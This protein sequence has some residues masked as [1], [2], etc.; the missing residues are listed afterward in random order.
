MVD[1]VESQ[2]IT[3][4][5]MLSAKQDAVQRMM[6][7]MN[8]VIATWEQALR[9][10]SFTTEV[11]TALSDEHMLRWPN[12]YDGQ[13]W[14]LFIMDRDG[15]NCNP[16]R[17]VKHYRLKALVV[18]KL[19]SGEFSDDVSLILDNRLAYGGNYGNE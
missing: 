19:R 5:A 17:E 7:D 10:A 15:G 2:A 13:R 3:T 16:A 9:G 8:R 1:A 12:V 4:A 6:D 11:R 18:E 14:D